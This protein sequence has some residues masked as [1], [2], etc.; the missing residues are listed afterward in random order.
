MSNQVVAKLWWEAPHQGLLER[1]MVA[2]D[3]VSFGRGSD[4]D[5]RIGHAPVYAPQVPRRWGEISWHRG[6]VFIQNVSERWGL[7]LDPV[8]E[9]DIEIRVPVPPGVGAAPTATGS[10]MRITI[11]PGAGAAPP[12]SRV[13]ILAQAPGVEIRIDLMAARGVAVGYGHAED[14]PSFVPFTLTRTQRIIGRAVVAPFLT[15][16]PRRASYGDI[17]ATTHYAER[18]VRE[19]VAAMDGLFVVHRLANPGTAGDSLDRVAHTL[20]LHTALLTETR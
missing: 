14:P 18:T 2:S 13:G 15:G 16:G 12:V 19:A 7:V 17:A 20:R 11:Q 4:C 10:E 6:N 8:V 1:F 9:T 3:L 5:I